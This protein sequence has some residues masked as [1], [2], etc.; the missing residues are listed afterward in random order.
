MAKWRVFL[1]VGVL[2]AAAAGSIALA[3]TGAT[4]PGA[5]NT[6]YNG[7]GTSTPVVN[8]GTGSIKYSCM[9]A[10]GNNTACPGNTRLACKVSCDDHC[11]TC[12]ASAGATYTHAKWT[13]GPL[14]VGNCQITTTGTTCPGCQG[15]GQLICAVGDVYTDGACTTKPTPNLKIWVLFGGTKPCDP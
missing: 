15:N 13:S 9:V 5:A 3:A 2:I 10:A 1:S 7:S 11:D 8:F 4:A 12:F 6:C 14:C